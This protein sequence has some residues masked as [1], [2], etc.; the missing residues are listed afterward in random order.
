MDGAGSTLHPVSGPTGHGDG[1][2]PSAPSESTPEGAT[3]TKNGSGLPAPSH[4]EHTWQPSLRATQLAPG[5]GLPGA[6]C[7][8]HLAL[9]LAG[10]CLGS[11][12]CYTGLRVASA[13][14]DCG[15]R[16]VNSVKG[17]S[18]QPPACAG[19]VTPLPWASGH[20]VRKPKVGKGGTQQSAWQ[21]PVRLP[22]GR[23]VLG[24]TSRQTNRA[25]RPPN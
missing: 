7:P 21:V 20:V 23:L 1:E 10:L 17:G 3:G 12:I 16:L 25:T 15:T 5:N 19:P 24:A 8:W 13:S 2:K 22:P 11:P 9:P 14:Q 6:G 4:R 18:A